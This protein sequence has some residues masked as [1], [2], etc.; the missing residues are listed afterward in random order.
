M[1]NLHDSIVCLLYGS[2][3]T[4]VAKFTEDFDFMAMN[5]KFKKDEVWGH[6]GKSNKSQSK[7][8]NGNVSDEA[9]MQDGDD[10]ELPKIEPVYSKD[11]FFDS[12]SCN[13]LDNGPNHGRTRYSEQMKLD[14]E[15]R[16]SLISSY[17]SY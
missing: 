17:S 10:A 13:A 11:D 3:R 8:E 2:Q 16:P 4:P 15:V 5:E 14:T 1:F 6:L 12:L 7:D 9:D